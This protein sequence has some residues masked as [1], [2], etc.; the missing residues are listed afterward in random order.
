MQ[1]KHL[2]LEDREARQEGGELLIRIQI[3]YKRLT[4]L[5]RKAPATVGV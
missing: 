3:E 1:L 2:V 4:K 5:S